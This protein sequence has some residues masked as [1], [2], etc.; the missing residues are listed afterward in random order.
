MSALVRKLRLSKEVLLLILLGIVIRIPVLLSP[1][2]EGYRNAQTAALTANM[3]EDGKLRLDPIAPWR[4]DLDARLVLEFPAY[5]LLVLAV[6]AI[7]GVPLDTAGRLVSLALWILSFILLQFLWRWALPSGA[8]LWANLLFVLAPLNWYA[9]AA[10]MPETL[11]QLLSIAFIL[12]CLIYT[13]HKS[14]GVCAGLILLAGLG[15]LVKFPAFV[16]L[17]LFAALVW[18]DRLGWRSLFRP[19]LLAGAMLLV[20]CLVAWGSYAD[21]VNSLHFDYWTGVRNLEGF[22]QIDRSRLSASYWFPLIA[23]NTTLI[24]GVVGAPLALLGFWSTLRRA[25]TSFS[26]RMWLYLLASLFAYWLIWSK[27]APA[28]SYYNLPNTVFLAAMFGLGCRWATRWMAKIEIAPWVRRSCIAT[29][30]AL[31]AGVSA[32]CWYYLYQPDRI[33]ITA[34]EWLRTNT[35]PDDLILFQPRHHPAAMDYEHQT[36]LSHAAGRKTWIWTRTTPDKE[37]ARALRKSSYIVVTNPS[38]ESGIFERI[39]QMIKGRTPDAPEAIDKIRPELLAEISSGEGYTIFGFR[40]P[41][42]H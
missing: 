36:L 35:Q 31:L 14:L 16:H 27:A 18:L 10:F 33:T 34:A 30:V 32:G 26:S 25:R 4:G 37:K 15:L 6:D 13:K 9:G 41:N 7:P 5:N 12:L 40:N 42:P 11:V 1:I 23:Y 21:S 19:V 28:Q 3:I 20:G 2:S 24:L 38:M 8:R 17:G 29:L 22:I 39:R